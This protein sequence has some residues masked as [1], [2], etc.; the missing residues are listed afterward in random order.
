MN[1]YE[2]YSVNGV[3]DTNCLEEAL[4]DLGIS[5]NLI[6][7]VLIRS[8]INSLTKEFVERLK[9]LDENENPT[10][11]VLEF[12]LM[13]DTMK[14]ITCDKTK[15][16]ELTGLTERMIDEKRRRREI[17][18]FQLSGQAGRGKKII[19]YDPYKVMMVL[20]EKKVEAV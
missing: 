2:K 16:S 3:F 15:L 6:N 9:S 5:K 19:V 7:Q 14:P 8:S 18:Y 4:T 20:E 1:I 17:P 11:M 10:N 13:A 12:F